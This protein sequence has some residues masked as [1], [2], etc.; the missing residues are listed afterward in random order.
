VADLGINADELGVS[1][2]YF[3][4]CPLKDVATVAA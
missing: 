2:K 3:V 1:D 4:F